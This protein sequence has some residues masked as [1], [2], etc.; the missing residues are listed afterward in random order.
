MRVTT[1]DA[2]RIKGLCRSQNNTNC[3]GCQYADDIYDFCPSTWNAPQLAADLLEARKLLKKAIDL[4][5]YCNE[6]GVSDFLER[7]KEYAE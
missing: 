3:Y 1:K 7:T 2:E 6:D 5:E 4:L